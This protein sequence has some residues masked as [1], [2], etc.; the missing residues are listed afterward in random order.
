MA[1]G[2]VGAD[3][4]GILADD[5]HHVLDGLGV[6]VDGRV[7]ALGQEGR[8]H[9]H[10]DEAAVVGDE[11]QLFIGLVAR[12]FFQ[13]GRQAVRVA[14]RLLR[15][16]DHFLAGLAAD[17]GQVAHD[18]DP[19]HLGDDLAA[20]AGQAAVAF[21]AAGA[22]QVLGVVAHLH[23]AHAELLEHLDIADLVLEGVGV[24]EA[25]EDAGL[26]LLLGLADIGGA[27]YR[28]HQVAVVAD[29]L[30]AGGDVVHRGLETLPYRHR[31]VG[32]GQAALAHVL[33][34]F[35]VPF[36]DDQAVDDDTVGV[37]FCWAHQAVPFVCCRQSR[38]WR[39][40]GSISLG[41]RAPRCKSDRGIAESVKNRSRT[42]KPIRGRAH[43]RHRPL[44]LRNNADCQA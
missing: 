44:G 41:G 30:L 20:E 39:F 23:D 26:A 36:G 27:A 3:A 33:E 43:R 2:E 28:D 18:A 24:L 10:A 37:Y 7:D 15:F 4:D 25:E 22:D 17:V 34:Q 6:V 31:A 5:I 42:D 40:V 13:A 29:Q 19:V 38:C 21:V 11:F 12:V 8:E 35:A 1:L 32:R 9:G 14:H 16:E